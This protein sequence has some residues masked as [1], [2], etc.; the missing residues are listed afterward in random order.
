MF[1]Q[2]AS[3]L[4]VGDV[5]PSDRELAVLRCLRDH[6]VA[7]ISTVA[8]EVFAAPRTTFGRILR[9]RPAE[10]ALAS[11]VSAG[12]VARSGDG[13]HAEFTLTQAGR[14]AIRNAALGP[15]FTA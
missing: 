9:R 4:S 12:L 15:P 14:Q 5:G 2:V 1:E 10:E 11:L 8:H 3:L 7:T 6:S 13:D